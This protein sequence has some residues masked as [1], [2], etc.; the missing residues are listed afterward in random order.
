YLSDEQRKLLG[1]DCN[2]RQALEL[3]IELA[4]RSGAMLEVSCH[5]CGDQKPV[6]TNDLDYSPLCIHRIMDEIAC[7]S[8]D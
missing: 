3:R 6:Y 2:L 7:Q 1:F 4:R 8:A 5:P